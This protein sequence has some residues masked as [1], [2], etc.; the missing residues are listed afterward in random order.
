MP[1]VIP[2]AFL[3]NEL[4]PTPP[5]ERVLD[6]K[7][8]NEMLRREIVILRMQIDLQRKWINHQH[9]TASWLK[10]VAKEV[11]SAI[12]RLQSATFAMKY[13]EKEVRE[14]VELLSWAAGNG[15]EAVVKLLL[16]KVGVDPDS[17]D[18]DG[19]TSAVVKLLLPE[20]GVDPDSKDINSRTP[21]SWAA[22][23]GR[24]G[25]GGIAACQG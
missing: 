11:I 2:P 19:Q 20:D 21:L 5:P 25:V 22:A 24:E 3:N 16:A 10:S 17:K 9:Q 8:E 23:N 18:T 6:L 4:P 14:K 13:T 12:Q 15:H 1:N 7:L